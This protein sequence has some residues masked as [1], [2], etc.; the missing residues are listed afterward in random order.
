MS[1]LTLRRAELRDLADLTAIYNYYVEHTPVTFDLEPFSVEER[2]PWFDGFAAR[3]PHQMFV[4][5]REEDG[6][7]RALGYACSHRFR[8]KAA[9]APSVE[10]S[11][12]CAPDAIGRGLGS[13]LY[14]RLFQALASAPVHRAY[15]GITVPNTRS[16]SLHERLGFEPL[17]TFSEVGFKMDRY[18]D[19]LWLQKKL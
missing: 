17:A 5:V 15:A 14:A 6:G 7:E 8:P 10:V 1:E 3:G 18:W 16:V 9:Y 19:V 2:R 4:A 13:A 11:V 12:Y